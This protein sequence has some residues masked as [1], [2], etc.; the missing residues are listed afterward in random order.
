MSDDV[1]MDATPRRIKR[2]NMGQ[3]PT[4]VELHEPASVDEL[5]ALIKELA[6]ADRP[7]TV[8]GARS[9]VVGALD[10]TADVA[11][12]TRR[13]DEVIVFDQSSHL[14][15]VGAGIL[16]GQLEAWLN[17]RGCT[18]GQYPQSLHISSVG[19]WIATRATGAVSARNGGV[20]SAIRGATVVLADGSIVRLGPRVRPPGGLDGL[21]V[22]VGS[23]GSL[24]VV[25]EVTFEVRSL[26][27][28]RTACFLFPDLP[29]V[30]EAQRTLMQG[31]YPV[32][33]LRG[34]NAAESSHVLGTDTGRRCL[35]MLSTIGPAAVVE[36]QIRAIADRL[37]ELDAERLDDHAASRWYAERYD[38]ARMMEDRNATSGRAF[39]TIEVSVPWSSAA[40]CADEMETV[41]SAVSDPFYLHFSHAYESGVCFYSLLWLE[42]EGGDAAVLEQLETAWE[43]ALDIVISHG[44]T[45]GHHHGIGSL[46]GHRYQQSADATIHAALKRALDPSDLLRA[47]LLNPG[48]ARLFVDHGQM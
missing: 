29:A 5:Q 9:N 41:L 37:L 15:T 39:D 8:V 35:L 24:G 47:R 4:S 17:D 44:G 21:G 7:F 34:Y 25:V 36:T 28:E 32:A 2:R 46:R 48:D 38:V 6:S 11:V 3:A 10:T 23:E 16:G 20:E 22:F 19:G 27:P 45:I 43:Q 13:L 18:L 30:I 33:L 12:S 31:G 14:V 40:A 1:L 42:D 26:L